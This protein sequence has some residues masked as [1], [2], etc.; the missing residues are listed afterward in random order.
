MISVGHLTS[1]NLNNISTH[2]FPGRGQRDTPVA[3]FMVILQIIMLCPG[4]AAAN[5]RVHF[6]RGVCMTLYK[7]FL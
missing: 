4:R 2:K 7:L 1:V 3:P 6:S 5:G